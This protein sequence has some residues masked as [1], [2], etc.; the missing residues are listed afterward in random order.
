MKNAIAHLNYLH[1]APRKVRRIAHTLKGLSVMEAEAQLLLRP[2]R[3]AEPLLKL[4]RSAAAN[5]KNN[6]KM[7]GEKLVVEEIF[8][9]QGA[10]MK[11]MLPRAMGRATPIQKKM[12]HVTIRLAEKDAVAA[13]RFVITPPPKKDKKEKTGASPKRHATTRSAEP[14]TSA[15]KANEKSGFLKRIFRRKSI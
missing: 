8:V 14:K 12:S 2:Q 9:N 6:G 3:S 15:E 1:M 4:L 13:P 7:N 10:M 5:A 11:R